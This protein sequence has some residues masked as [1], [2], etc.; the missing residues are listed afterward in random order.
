MWIAVAVCLW[1]KCRWGILHQINRDETRRPRRAA[2]K[3]APQQRPSI[4]Y[5]ILDDPVDDGRRAECPPT[6]TEPLLRN[7]RLPAEPSLEGGKS[8]WLAEEGQWLQPGKQEENDGVKVCPRLSPLG[9]IRPK[10]L[11]DGLLWYLNRARTDELFFL[12]GNG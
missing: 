6:P 11:A 1:S 8:I 2:R 4:R 3:K 10:R 12:M 5:E 9:N 7:A